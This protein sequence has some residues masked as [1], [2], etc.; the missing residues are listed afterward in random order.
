SRA[1]GKRRTKRRRGPG[2]F[3]VATRPLQRQR[4]N[5]AKSRHAVTARGEAPHK[6]PRSGSQPAQRL[7]YTMQGQRAALDSRAW[8]A[9]TK[10]RQGWKNSDVFSP[11]LAFLRLQLHRL[12][13]NPL[14]GGWQHP[15]QQVEK[16]R[17]RAN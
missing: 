16:L 5:A 9:P 7:A 17:I 13:K 4:P 14:V 6:L 12:G 15:H 2:G 8:P 11:A 10:A 3:A 1:L